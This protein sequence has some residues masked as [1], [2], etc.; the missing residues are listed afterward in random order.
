[1]ENNYLVHHG[2]KGQR[3]GIRRWQNPD[4]SLTPAGREHY[5]YG[6]ERTASKYDIKRLKAETNAKIKYEK[7]QQKMNAKLEKVKNAEKAKKE[8]EKA[9]EKERKE[10]EKAEQHAREVAEQKRQLAEFKKKHPNKFRKLKPY[11]TKEGI[12]NDAGRALFFGNGDKKNIS[13]MSDKDL[14]ESTRRMNLEAQYRQASQNLKNMTPAT[15]KQ[16]MLQVVK[17]GGAEFAL[18]L[19]TRTLGS[20]LSG[21]A[22]NAEAAGRAFVE[23]SRRSLGDAFNAMGYEATSA[24]NLGRGNRFES[25]TDRRSLDQ[26]INDEVTSRVQRE[27]YEYRINSEVQARVTAA[28]RNTLNDDVNRQLNS[29]T[30]SAGEREVLTQLQNQYSRY[31]PNSYSHY[32]NGKKK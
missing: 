30:I 15:S 1:M 9:A 13:Q 4:G 11:L 25:L 18:Q 2:T 8:K 29:S 7:A 23:N 3:W 21:D 10:K 16:K 28:V 6:D 12:L 24:F 20:I 14:M 22:T 26:R 31:Q 32:Q 17:R 5:G 27:L 19:G